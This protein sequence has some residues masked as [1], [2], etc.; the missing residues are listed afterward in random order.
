M[1]ASQTAITL[2]PIVSASFAIAYGLMGELLPASIVSG[3]AL[4]YLALAVRTRLRGPSLSVR[5]AFLALTVASLTVTVNIVGGATTIHAAWLTIYPVLA[6]LLLELRG[7]A[8]HLAV[9]ATSIGITLLMALL[10]EPAIVIPHPDHQLSFQV[11][12]FLMYTAAALTCVAVGTTQSTLAR[13]RLE[14]LN[15]QLADENHTRRRAE[16]MA[17][18]TAEAQARFLATMSHEIRTPLHGLLGLTELVLTRDIDEQARRWLESALSSG[19]HLSLIVDDVLDLSKLKA[20]GLTLEIVPVDLGRLL[21]ECASTFQRPALDKGLDFI[22]DVQPPTGWQVQGDPTR[23]RQIVFNLLGNAIKFTDEGQVTL[24]ARKTGNDVVVSII[25]TGEGIPA[26]ELPRLFLPFEQASVST[27]RRH[28]GTGLGLS[29]VRGLVEKMG[30][31][32]TLNSEEGRGT[33]ASVHL[34]LRPSEALPV[35]DRVATSTK[36]ALHGRVLVVD[37]EP[38]NLI[39]AEAALEKL[40]VEVH[41]AN[42]GQEAITMALSNTFDLVLM[43]GHMPDMDGYQAASTIRARAGSDAP[44]IV[45]FTASTGVEDHARAKASGMVGLLPKPLPPDALQ[46]LLAQWIPTPISDRVRHEAVPKVVG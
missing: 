10:G 2:G 23:L 37:D 26:D 16:A 44:P 1:T 14:E 29:I 40:G 20:H 19:N 38:L 42:T 27:T 46:E 36:Q 35:P 12:S 22:V 39:V 11:F 17:I 21:E 4:G 9:F 7:L 15:Q 3:S 41:T 6:W 5:W 45:V 25:D 34:T 33:T 8:V 43:D 24:S 32:L 31:K 28:G 13:K 18:G 30:G